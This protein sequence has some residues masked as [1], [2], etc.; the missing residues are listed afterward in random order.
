V[1]GAAPMKLIAIKKLEDCLDGSMIFKYSFTET[2]DETRMK[3]LAERGKLHYYP[4]FPRPFFKIT[5]NDG[6]LLKGIIGDHDFE[7][8]FPFTNKQEKK[9]NFEAL[10]EK[11]I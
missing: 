4:E 10:L 6:V 3:I 5:T 11:M 1:N 7:A 8:V 9:E 2:I